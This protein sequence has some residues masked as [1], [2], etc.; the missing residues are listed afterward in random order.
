MPIFSK[1]HYEWLATHHY[2]QTESAKTEADRNLLI[3]A[4]KQLAFALVSDNPKFDEARFLDK[5][6]PSRFR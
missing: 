1:R 6:I 4:T 2:W 5:A 3:E